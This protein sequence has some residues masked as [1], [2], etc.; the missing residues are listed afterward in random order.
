MYSNVNFVTPFVVIGAISGAAFAVFFTVVVPW[1]WGLS[2][3]FLH[4][5]T[6]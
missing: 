2:K 3:P 5:I 6:G 4:A 1:L